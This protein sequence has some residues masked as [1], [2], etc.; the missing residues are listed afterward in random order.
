MGKGYHQEP[1][2][3]TTKRTRSGQQT[4]TS[5]R[6]S[7]VPIR[8]LYS[9]RLYAVKRL[10]IDSG[11]EGVLL[12]REEREKE[13]KELSLRV[14]NMCPFS[15]GSRERG[16][17]YHS[18]SSSSSLVELIVFSS[19]HSPP[20][21]QVISN[22]HNSYPLFIQTTPESLLL[23]AKNGTD[24]GSGVRLNEPAK[25][26]RVRLR[27]SLSRREREGGLRPLS[28]LPLPCIEWVFRGRL[29]QS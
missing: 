2:Q 1:H 20:L 17:E 22:R 6:E 3:T 4:T 25:R 10:S 9:H 23:G 26:E 28:P 15:E 12:C 18:S 29:S 14:S 13:R 19:S 8:S 11:G 5:Q 7:T 16:K 27:E 24:A 21:S